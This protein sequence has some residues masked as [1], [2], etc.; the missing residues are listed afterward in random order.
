MR[1]TFLEAHYENV[2]K[3]VSNTKSMLLRNDCQSP[4]HRQKY[5]LY[6]GKTPERSW[7]G[8]SIWLA[9]LS[10]VKST[11]FGLKVIDKLTSMYGEPY[12]LKRETVTTLLHHAVTRKRYFEMSQ[13]AVTMSPKLVSLAMR[14]GVEWHE[15]PISFRRSVASVFHDGE[16]VMILAPRSVVK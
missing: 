15:I 5:S 10:F 3:R 14:M 6:T 11:P 2:R 1:R 16:L 9:R 13:M 7:I 8:Q 12:P 4:T